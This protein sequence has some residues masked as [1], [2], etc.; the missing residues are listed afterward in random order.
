LA[1]T[2]IVRSPPPA[3]TVA[4]VGSTVSDAQAVV[5]GEGALGFRDVH[6]TAEAA[7]MATTQNQKPP[8]TQRPPRNRKVGTIRSLLQNRALSATIGKENDRLRTIDFPTLDEMAPEGTGTAGGEH[9]EPPRFATEDYR[10]TLISVRPDARA[11]HGSS[12]RRCPSA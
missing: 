12:T 10:P 4:L 6:P 2:A 7:A 9:R 8:D 3:S 1:V 11:T 5:G